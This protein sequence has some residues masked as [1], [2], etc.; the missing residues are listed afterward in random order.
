MIIICLLCPHVKNQ[1]AVWNDSLPQPRSARE[2]GEAGGQR[3][4]VVI[5]A[6]PLRDVV[7]DN[8]LRPVRQ[9]RISAVEPDIVRKRIV[10][11]IHGEAQPELR[12]S[13]FANV[14]EIH[15][16]HRPAVP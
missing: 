7:L 12:Q 9:D 5:P 10:I 16:P 8:Q 15:C 2:L 3:V 4:T 11:I 6:H 1:L 13:T 14:L